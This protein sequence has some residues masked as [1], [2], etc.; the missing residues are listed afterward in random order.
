MPRH[1]LGAVRPCGGRVGGRRGRG[2]GRFAPAD[3]MPPAW[4]GEGHLID[5]H[6]GQVRVSGERRGAGVVGVG[7]GLVTV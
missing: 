3:E 7:V 6:W 2:Y 1:P 4:L 5:S